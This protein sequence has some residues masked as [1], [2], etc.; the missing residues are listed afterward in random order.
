MDLLGWRQTAALLEVLLEMLNCSSEFFH[1]RGILSD[2]P[3][4]KVS[5]HVLADTDG[6]PNSL[7]GESG[8]QQKSRRP[9]IATYTYHLRCVSPKCWLATLPFLKCW[10][11]KGILAKSLP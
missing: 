1:T 11:D 2:A 8:K 4:L 10:I 6:S 7:C 9:S 3:G 5:N